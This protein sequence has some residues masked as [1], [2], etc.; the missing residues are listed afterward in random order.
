MAPMVYWQREVKMA[1]ADRNQS[2]LDSEQNSRKKS[3]TPLMG[4]ISSESALKEDVKDHLGEEGF[5]W[6]TGKSSSCAPDRNGT[7]E[8]SGDDSVFDGNGSKC[9]SSDMAG[10]DLSDGADGV[11]QEGSENGRKRE[12]GRP[13][14][15]K[16]LIDCPLAW[17]PQTEP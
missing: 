14:S 11:L 2:F 10:E 13:S 1:G 5:N 16:A 7:L 3:L 12:R 6:L 15:L 8:K 9:P 4:W 17:V